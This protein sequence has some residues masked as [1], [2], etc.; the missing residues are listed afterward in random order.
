MRR[1]SLEESNADVAQEPT[2]SQGDSSLGGC[3]S[4]ALDAFPS[5]ETRNSL[6]SGPYHGS[7]LAVTKVSLTL[8]P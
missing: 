7:S 1:V 6:H 8:S 2:D 5:C 4:G 3:G